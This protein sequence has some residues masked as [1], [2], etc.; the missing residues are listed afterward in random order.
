MRINTPLAPLLSMC[1]NTYVRFYISG[2][3]NWSNLLKWVWKQESPRAWT[4]E[5]YR[6][7]RSRFGGGGC[8]QT[9]SVKTLPSPHPSDAGGDNLFRIRIFFFANINHKTLQLK[10]ES[11]PAWLQEVYPV[12]RV[13]QD[14]CNIAW[15]GVAPILSRG[16][17]NLS[18]PGW[19]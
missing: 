3:V 14:S 9:D 2:C 15:P 12:Q 8:G 7:L 16:E 11:L 1:Y 17:Y 6:P 4:K 13:P 18:C 5:A 19:G 10:Q